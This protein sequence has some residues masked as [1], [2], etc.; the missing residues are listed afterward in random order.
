MVE[1]VGKF[2][3]LVSPVLATGVAALMLFASSYSYQSATCMADPASPSEEEC[4]RDSGTVSGFQY[5]LENGDY[6]LLFWA[7]FIVVV[8]LM[9]AVSAFFGRA[10][11]VWVCAASLLFLSILGMMS[12]GL[13]VLP[14]ALLLF[15]SA[16]LLTLSR[17]VPDE[18]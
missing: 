15:S 13:F 5:A 14:L 6:A 9:A 17:L 11:S 16:A 3:A 7:G 2:L 18:A 4:T 8:C 1:K 12:I 10:A